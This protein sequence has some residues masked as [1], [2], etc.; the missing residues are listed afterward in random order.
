MPYSLVT[1]ASNGRFSF[2]MSPD[3]GDPSERDKGFGYAYAHGS[4]NESELLW[5]TEGW[6]AFSVFLSRDGETLVRMG[7]WPRGSAPSPENLAVAF[8]FEGAIQRQYSTAEL[9]KDLS[10][11]EP[12]V[13]HY[14]YR[15]EDHPPGFVRNDTQFRLVTV[16][17][18]EYLFDLPTGE[19]LSA[20]PVRS[21]FHIGVPY[22]GETGYALAGLALLVAALVLIPGGAALLRTE[23]ATMKYSGA[24]VHVTR[25]QARLLGVVI[26]LV[27]FICLLLALSVVF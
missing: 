24:H 7:N 21:W 17:G 15:S 2:R 13:S 27:G 23:S 5:T 10:K 18:L 22:P 6:Y 19:V 26:A 1:V 11:V 9:I 25:S 16:D 20:R 14:R 4:L 8:Y 3:P 12:S